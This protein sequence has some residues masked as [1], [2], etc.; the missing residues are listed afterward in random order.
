MALLNP[1]SEEA[2]PEVRLKAIADTIIM[3]IPGFLEDSAKCLGA[4]AFPFKAVFQNRGADEPEISAIVRTGNGPVHIISSD[5]EQQVS[6]SF[7]KGDHGHFVLQ[8]KDN[9]DPEKAAAVLVSV[10]S[11]ILSKGY[12]LETE[13]SVHALLTHPQGGEPVAGTRA[14]PK[15]QR[16]DVSGESVSHAG[17]SPVSPLLPRK[18]LGSAF[19]LAAQ[20]DGKKSPEQASTLSKTYSVDIKDIGEG[21]SGTLFIKDRNEPQLSVKF[22]EHAAIFRFKISSANLQQMILEPIGDRHEEVS[23]PAV[24]G[25][26]ERTLSS[27]ILDD[28]KRVPASVLREAGLS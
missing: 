24:I 15:T 19:N 26:L 1:V 23:I 13:E 10:S 20:K 14:L 27:L 6:F 17:S 25:G 22:G 21:C 18:L 16:A 11:K 28:I 5:T 2:T 3:Q 4:E 12:T 9:V 8:T 7:E